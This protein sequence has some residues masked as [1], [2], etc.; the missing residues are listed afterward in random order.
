MQNLIAGGHH[1]RR[2]RP[3]LAVEPH[4]LDAGQQ[5]VDRLVKRAGDHVVGRDDVDAL[6]ARHARQQVPVNRRQAQWIESAI[7]HGDDDVPVGRRRGRRQHL[8]HGAVLIDSGLG[9]A[10][11]EVAKRGDQKPRL[12]HQALGAA[13]V[14]RT[15][16][17]QPER[18][19]LE[20]VDALLVE[21]QGVVEAQH[22]GHEPGTQPERRFETRGARGA[23]GH[24]E[25]RLA[26]G[27]RQQGHVGQATQE[28]RHQLAHRQRNRAA[29]ACPRQAGVDLRGCGA[30]ARPRRGWGRRSGG[31]G[32]PAPGPG[33][34]SRPPRSGTRRDPPRGS[35]AWSAW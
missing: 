25:K 30:A 33:R 20:R 19:P 21:A 4:L 1:Q 32:R 22:L 13:I 12:A 11:F 17:Q 15:R 16:L 34:T 5:L 35:G 31:R 27:F 14:G 28:R 29:P 2:H 26:L 7:A 6:Q 18:Q 23:A 3:R 10:R 9:A 24:T 8:L